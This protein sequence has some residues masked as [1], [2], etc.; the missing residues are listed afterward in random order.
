MHRTLYYYTIHFFIYTYNHKK[1]RY[2]RYHKYTVFKKCKLTQYLWFTFPGTSSRTS[3]SF[4]AWIKA[5]VCLQCVIILW[6]WG[7]SNSW[8]SSP[9]IFFTIVASFS[10]PKITYLIKLDGGTENN[11]I[12]LVWNEMKPDWGE[13]K[14][15]CT[16]SLKVEVCNVFVYSCWCIFISI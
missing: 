6:T 12:R 8:T 7:L 1:V 13:Y 15:V 9:I 4:M 16:G 3:H 14:S 10:C 2:D 11:I 5:R